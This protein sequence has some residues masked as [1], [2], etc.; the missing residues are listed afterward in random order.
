VVLQ[1]SVADLNTAYRNYFRALAEV[2]AAR[3]RGEKAKLKVRKPKFKSKRHDQALRVTRAGRFHILASGRL[4]LPK[5]GDVPV[6][7]SQ[8][9]PSE[10]SSVTVTLDGAGR[11]HASFVVEVHRQPLPPA[12]QEVGIDLGLAVFAV[13][14]TGETVANP[15]WLRNQERALRRSQ[16]NLS[17][18]QKG[19]ANRDKARFRLAKQ[20]AKVADARREFHHQLST[21]L[22]RENQ[23]VYV[24]DLNVAALGRSKLAK[25]IKDAGWGQ[26]TAMLA[27]KA[28]L[29][30]RTLVK[31]DRWFP[32]SQLC[33]VCGHRDGPK[34]LKVRAWVCPECGAEHDRD[35]N[36]ARNILAEGRSV[37]ACGGDVRRGVTLAVADEAGTT[38][39]VAA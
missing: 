25:S 37:A 7:W 23:A 36:A 22:I 1:Q 16:R 38:P 9:L 11:Y 21:R 33:S 2:K 8:P 3:A 20:H 6:R 35:V 18:R 24:E 13:L 32:S 5:I 27:Y 15:C 10:P 19:S 12:G 17:R 4:R 26:F 30:G 31:L 28:D 39:G 34:P 14:S 29:Y